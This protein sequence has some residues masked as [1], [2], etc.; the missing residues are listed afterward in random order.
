MNVHDNRLTRVEYA[1]IDGRIS[2][3]LDRLA[4][5]NPRYKPVAWEWER[6]AWHAIGCDSRDLRDVELTLIGQQVDALCQAACGITPAW[7]AATDPR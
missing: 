4:R 5:S 1:A 6:S 3:E 7:H 2:A